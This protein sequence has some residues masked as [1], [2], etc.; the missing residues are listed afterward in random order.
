M[1]VLV[2]DEVG[3]TCYVH[4]RLLEELGYEVVCAS[5]GFEALTILEQDSEIRIVFSELVMRELDGLD[6][7][8]KVQKQEHYTDD[9]QLEAPMFFVMTTLQPSDKSQ[10]RLVER[11]EL[12]KKLGITGVIYKSRDRE[13][14]KTVF[15]ETLRTTLGEL[16]EAAP[17]DICTPAETL[18]EVVKDIIEAKNLEAAEEFYNLIIAQS[19]YLEFFITSSQKRAELA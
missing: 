6:L 3:Y 18:C 17:I 19:E 5:S 7:F 16:S 1:R 9:G 11:L 8:L 2:V 15:S 14:L 10:T 13:E 12:A 4:T